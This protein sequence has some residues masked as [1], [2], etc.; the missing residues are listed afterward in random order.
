M[1]REEQLVHEFENFFKLRDELTREI[2]LECSRSKMTVTQLAYLKTICKQEQMTF[3]RLAEITENSKPTI[4]G[5]IDRFV[6]MDCVYRDP[7][8]DDRRIVY[9]QLT[10]KG[11]KIAQAEQIALDRL[12][13][14]M[15]ESLSKDEQD[16]LIEILQKI[17]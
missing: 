17:W 2:L 5:M 11:K 15:M 8:P 1:D 10:E 16:F 7:C 14:R 6:E 9:I 12:I 13:E 3:S 4:T